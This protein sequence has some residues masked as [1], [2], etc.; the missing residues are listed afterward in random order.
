MFQ[1]LPDRIIIVR[2]FVS[3]GLRIVGLIAGIGI[4]FRKNL[5][6]RLALALSFFTILTIYW[7]HPINCF[8]IIFDRIG[9]QILATS[10]IADQALTVIKLLQSVMWVTLVIVYIIDLGFSICLIYYFTRPK[11]KEQ[12]R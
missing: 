2:Y 11:V 10:A 8:R 1:Y 7:K 5:F 6:R 9:Q 3:I 12:F 4:L